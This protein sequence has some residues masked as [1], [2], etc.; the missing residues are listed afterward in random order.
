MF[1]WRLIDGAIGGLRTDSF[2]RSLRRSSIAGSIVQPV[3]FPF[4]SRLSAVE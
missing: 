2:F 1:P 4:E 3:G